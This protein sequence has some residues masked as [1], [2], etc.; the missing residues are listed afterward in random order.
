ME[1][2]AAQAFA[3]RAWERY[4]MGPKELGLVYN[5]VLF[6]PEGIST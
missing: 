4:Q 6:F 3:A 5:R 2:S 1:R